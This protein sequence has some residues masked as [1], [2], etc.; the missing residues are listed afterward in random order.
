MKKYAKKDRTGYLLV[1][2]MMLGC[3]LFYV[4]PFFMV[5]WYSFRS[6]MSRR[7]TFVGFKNYVNLINNDMFLLAAKNTV[8]F[9]LL[10]LPLILILSYAI[11]LMLKN[12]ANRHEMLKSVLLFPYI[13]P[14]VGSVVLVDLLFANTGLMNQFMGFLGLQS[15]NW[16]E[17][18]WS[19]VIIILLY[20]WK[21]T[22]YSVILLLSGLMAI[23]ERQYDCADMDGAGGLQKFVYIT[24]PQMWHSVFF[25]LLFSLVNAFKCFREIFLIGGKYPGT[26]IYML[27]HF[28]NNN[29]ESLNFSQLSAASVL[30]FIVIVIVAGIAYQWV[31]RKEV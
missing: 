23:P 7:S 20:L 4:I 6:G 26:D 25:A 11:A 10:G 18:S 8:F 14:V 28:I 24:M 30:L 15:T 19:F 22:G 27:Q 29:F 21:N 3:L 13:M 31:G 1:L 9:L 16:M 17:S 2:P 5:V 12:Q